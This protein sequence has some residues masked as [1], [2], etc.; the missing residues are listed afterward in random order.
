MIVLDQDHIPNVTAVINVFVEP[1]QA[2]LLQNGMNIRGILC[3]YRTAHILKICDKT[4]RIFQMC[5]P[6]CTQCRFWIFDSAQINRVILQLFSIC[7]G[8]N[9]RFKGELTLTTRL[10]RRFNMCVCMCIGCVIFESD[11]GLKSICV[12]V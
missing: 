7:I 10:G 2:N 5:F 11:M 12:S 3:A 4:K 8:S 6:Q 9:Y 1:R